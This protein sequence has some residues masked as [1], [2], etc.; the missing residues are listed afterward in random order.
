MLIDWFT[1]A[2]QALNF[3]ALVW[4][5]KRF[6]YRPVLEAIDAREARIAAQLAD[7][8]A[9][10]HD[11]TAQR[12]LYQQQIAAL[13]RERAER[14]ASATAE[15]EAERKRLVDLARS[16]AADIATRRRDALDAQAQ[17][18]D[19]ELAR[20]ATQEVFAVSRRALAD[21][22]AADLDDRIAIVFSDRLR[23]LDASGRAALLSAL[24]PPSGGPIAVR[25]A[26]ELPAAGQASIRDALHQLF[27]R[28]IEVRF[29]AGAEL[30][31]GIELVAGGYRF[32]W[33]IAHYL[34]ALERIASETIASM[35]TKAAGPAA[36]APAAAGAAA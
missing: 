6:L 1:V 26:H 36:E 18:L 34:D 4:L 12:D 8:A 32:S 10:Q 24:D 13:E 21:L 7:A 9:R 14:L 16:A 15:A 25:S 28:A 30:I 35:E 22:A 17:Q 3:V 23:A 19:R 11:A 31:G 20:R 33:D 29:E 27:G 5:L 2:A